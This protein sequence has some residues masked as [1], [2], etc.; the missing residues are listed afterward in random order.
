MRSTLLASLSQSKHEYFDKFIWWTYFYSKDNQERMIFVS[1]RSIFN[2][3]MS[4]V[5]HETVR[6]LGMSDQIYQTFRELQYLSDK[7]YFIYYTFA[8]LKVQGHVQD[9]IVKATCYLFCQGIS[10]MKFLKIED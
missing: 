9:K 10:G 6:S 1:K 8:C 3:I 7:Y 5:L 4:Y 2:T